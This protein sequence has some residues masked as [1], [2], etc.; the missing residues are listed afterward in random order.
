MKIIHGWVHAYP[1]YCSMCGGE[2]PLIKDN[3]MVYQFETPSICPH[4][5]TELAVSYQEVEDE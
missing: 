1:A 5:N 3:D 2:A 4:C